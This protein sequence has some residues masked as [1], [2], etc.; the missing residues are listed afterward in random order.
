MPAGRAQ[1]GTPPKVAPPSIAAEDLAT[2]DGHYQRAKEFW[3]DGQRLR[4][5]GDSGWVDE[6][7]KAYE[8]MKASRAVLSEYTDWLERADLDGWAI[9]AEYDGLRRIL[10]KHDPMF[11]KIKKVKQM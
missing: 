3:N 10:G 2:A 8:E 11:Q 9:P 7:Q 1:E 4:N 5:K 6:V